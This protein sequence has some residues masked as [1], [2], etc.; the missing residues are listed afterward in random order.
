M[1]KLILSVVPCLVFLII[2]GACQST[3]SVLLSTETL[4]PIETATATLV[5]AVIDT[6]T[7]T[8]TVMITPMITAT[9]IVARID[10]IADLDHLIHEIYSY[11]CIGF[12]F[13]EFP[14]ADLQ[15]SRL[16]FIDTNIQPDSKLYWVSEIADNVDHSRQ[17]FV[18]CDPTLCQDK[19]YVKVFNTTEEYEINWD[20]RLPWR[21]I[22][23]VTWINNNILA[24][25]QSANP[26]HGLIVAVDVDRRKILYE[27]VVFPDY[28][29]TPFTPPLSE[30]KNSGF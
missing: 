4:L 12:N 10:S 14:S 17:A 27:A 21:P 24:F 5:P 25:F 20:A 3:A 28:Y 23:D 2:L 22:Q 16:E 29:C 7:P 8:A 11:P 19:I 6:P 1:R 13:A 18:A 15:P 26:D 30:I 9:P